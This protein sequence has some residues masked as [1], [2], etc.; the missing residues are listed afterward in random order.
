MSRRAA[1]SSSASDGS[2]GEMASAELEVHSDLRVCFCGLKVGMRM[3]KTEGNPGR[4]FFGCS[5][6]ST[7]LIKIT[8]DLAALVNVESFIGVAC[9][10][11]FFLMKDLRFHLRLVLRMFHR[12]LA[13]NY[14]EWIDP[15]PSARGEDAIASM[16]RKM[17]IIEEK[18]KIME[19]DMKMK[20]EELK[21]M[22][23]EFRRS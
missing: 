9:M 2:N 13:C 17:K 23:E 12:H 21:K 5:R 14:F 7:N 11:Y 1:S 6:Y 4:R 3:S 18:M 16:V 10:S 19:E 8:I 15:P 20:E 22:E